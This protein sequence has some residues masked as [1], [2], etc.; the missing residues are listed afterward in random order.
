MMGGGGQ[1][2]ETVLRST[3]LPVVD[4]FEWWREL[5]SHALM[6]TE[7]SSNHADDFRASIR[8]L[9]AVGYAGRAEGVQSQGPTASLLQPLAAMRHEPDH[10]AVRAS[11]PEFKNTDSRSGI[12]SSRSN[13]WSLSGLPWR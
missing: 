2:I 1:V 6:P 5:T 7:I 9:N 11:R 8:L 10:P 3:D 12:M 4:R 13:R